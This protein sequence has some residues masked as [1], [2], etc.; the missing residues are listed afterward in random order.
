MYEIRGLSFFT[1]KLGNNISILLRNLAGDKYKTI[2]MPVQGNITRAGVL[3]YV[4]G[5]MHIM[6][7]DITVASH[8]DFN[9]FKGLS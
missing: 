3:A 8:I 5:S 4:A 7:T 9:I 1:G 2:V 6:V